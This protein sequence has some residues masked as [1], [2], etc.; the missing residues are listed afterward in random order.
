[1]IPEG[2]RNM[3]TDKLTLR[4]K[5]ALK[6]AVQLAKDNHNSEVGTEHLLLA[7]VRQ[8]SGVVAPLLEKI[9]VSS[10]QF[11]QTFKQMVDSAPKAY[12]DHAQVN[13]ST[14]LNDELESAQR[15]AGSMKD[16]YLSAEHF[17]L[18]VLDDTHTRC[19]DALQKLGVTKTEV[20]AAL[21]ELRGGQT[22]TNDDPEAQYQTLEKYTIDMTAAAKSGKLDPVIG[23]DEEI[24]RV[25]Q[26][27]SRRTKN[28]PV[29]I[30]EPGVGKTAIV[31]GL[32]QRIANGD[33]PESLK[34]KRILSLDVGQ[35]VAGASYVG[36]FE[37]RMKGVINEVVRSEGK[38]IL[39][40]DELHTIIGA[41]QGGNS[42]TD[43]SQLIKPAL[44]RGELHT[45]GAT[46]LDEYRKYIETD[47]ALERRFQPVYCKE[48]SV[49]DTIAILRGL[50]EKYEVH[51]GVRIKDDALVAAAT[52]SNRYITNRFL[53]DKAIDL[54]DEAASQLKMEIES[55]PVEL[56]RLERKILQLKIEQ[57]SLENETDPSSKERLEKIKGELA[58]LNSQAGSMRLQWQ[59]ERDAIVGIKEK[60]TQLEQ[61]RVQEKDAERSGD[62]GRAA[63]IQHGEI[64]AL[65]QQIKEAEDK[66][67]SVQKDGRQLLREEVDEDDIARIVSSWTGVPVTKMRSSEKQKYLQLESILSKQVVGQEEAIK[68]V[69]NAIR[70]N[71]AGIGDAHR[72]LGSFLFAGPTGVGKTLLA[73]VLAGFLFDDEKALTRIDMS[74]YMEKY[75]VSRLIGAPPGYVGYDQGGQLTE[76]VRRRPYSVILFDE[77]EKAHPD[78]FNILLQVLDDGRLTDGQGRVVDFTNTVIIMTSNLGSADLLGATSFA[79]GK[80]RVMEAVRAAF[81]PEFINRIDEIVV[82]KSLGDEQLRSIVTLQLEEL[83]QR[84]EGR[85]LHL[86][87]DDKVVDLVF[88]KGYSPAYGARPIRR[89]VQD[90]VEDPLAE[91]LLEGVFLEGSTIHLSVGPT[92]EVAIS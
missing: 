71:K 17:L 11:E 34:G 85:N 2:E 76:V 83:K 67:N 90:Y 40:I 30:G 63:R 73:K 82:F 15:I 49:E 50:K 24:R 58:D 1:M 37:Q 36:Q 46:T 92:G 72:P 66:L 48:P 32:A 25:M 39:F 18:A 19:N 16:E 4:M 59:N 3:D 7:M 61:L 74:E 62:L 42:H 88:K 79:E 6:E 43:A 10:G 80:T 35:L 31:E 29:L 75:S 56:D 28:N 5:E 51:H 38:I 52:L 20:Q 41:G 84:L 65:M 68:A 60:K 91:K 87:W 8:Q 57:K 33:V 45:I 89:A 26:V 77:I 70:R 27:L 64:P 54:I 22:I 86:V 14:I 9:G 69:A 12:G 23:R 55:Q 81:K 13:F 47:K 21:K 44:A 53:P 78:V